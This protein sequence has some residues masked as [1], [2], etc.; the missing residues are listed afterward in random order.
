M[1]A[2]NGDVMVRVAFHPSKKTTWLDECSTS[3]G[4]DT[5]LSINL[6]NVSMKRVQ[7]CDCNGT[8]MITLFVTEATCDRCLGSGHYAEGR[9]LNE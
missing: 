1:Q 6:L 7:C 3:T 4:P 2:T 9:A 8:G 5:N